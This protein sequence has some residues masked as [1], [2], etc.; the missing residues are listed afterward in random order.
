MIDYMCQSCSFCF[1]NVKSNTG[2]SSCK[3]S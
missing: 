2:K 1:I 3:S